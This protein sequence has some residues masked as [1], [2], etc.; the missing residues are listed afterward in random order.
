M[1]LISQSIYPYEIKG[2]EPRAM[3]C[4][5]QKIFDKNKIFDKETN[6]TPLIKFVY[7]YFKEPISVVMHCAVYIYNIG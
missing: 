3:F 4:Y 2:V 6:E 7:I 5:W 1:F